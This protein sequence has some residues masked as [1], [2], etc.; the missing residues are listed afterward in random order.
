LLVHLLY[1]L[2][3]KDMKKITIVLAALLI[4]GVAIAEKNCKKNGAGKACCKKEAKATCGASATAAT[5]AAAIANAPKA[6][7][8]KGTAGAC[9]K[10]EAKAQ[11]TA[12][13]PAVKPTEAASN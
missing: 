6:C 9:K 10:D 4:T 7:C 12:P 2:K 11:A 13:A 1:N 8:K 5:T 3:I